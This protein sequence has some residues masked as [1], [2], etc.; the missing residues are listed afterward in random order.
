MNVPFFSIVVLVFFMI[1]S[2][3]CK[4]RFLKIFSTINLVALILYC[5]AQEDFLALSEHFDIFFLVYLSTF[6]AS[7]CL[8]KWFCKVYRL[9]GNNYVF[10][11]VSTYRILIFLAIGLSF[12]IFV[13]SVFRYPFLMLR[14]M[15]AERSIS[16]YISISFPMC[17]CY[18]FYLNSIQKNSQSVVVTIVLFVLALI[19]TSKIFFIIFLLF[20]IPWYRK[21][22]KLSFK[23]ILV[24]MLIGFSS[25]SLLH[26]IT[27]RVVGGNDSL[28]KNIIF[29]MEGYYIGGLAAFQTFLDGTMKNY[30]TSGG[31]IK[32]GKWVGNV[33]SGFY[34]L[35]AEKSY[36]FFI[37]R[38]F[39]VGFLYG[40]IWA[41]V[42]KNYF[43]RVLSIY[44]V[45]PVC[46][47]FFSDFFFGGWI[48]WCCFAAA[49]FV[50][51]SVKK[52]KSYKEMAC[53]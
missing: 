30:M 11:H 45:F 13:F 20:S 15:I 8:S 39:C 17:A 24:A 2:S 16:F 36:M 7:Y 37:A 6:V 21:G 14:S 23:I 44:S 38:C 4:D 28:I 27:N 34:Y 49:A 25:F 46:F 47:I 42:S 50:L 31:W 48:Q 32:T 3:L 52:K 29:T 1:V 26:I 19:S 18:L 5:S 43:W 51:N 33:Y 22:F 35:F 9:K 41:N 10:F 53:I 12:S 40:I